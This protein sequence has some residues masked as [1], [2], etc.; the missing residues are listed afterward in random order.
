MS[1]LGKQR[2]TKPGIGRKTPIPMMNELFIK[3]WAGIVTAQTVD[4]MQNAE[5]WQNSDRTSGNC[6]RRDS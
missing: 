4:L 3:R 1:G 5:F 6:P 2:L